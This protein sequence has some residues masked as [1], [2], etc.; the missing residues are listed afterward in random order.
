MMLVRNG[1]QKVSGAARRG[2]MVFI[3]SLSGASG[4]R[5][6]DTPCPIVRPLRR[7]NAPTLYISLTIRDEADIGQ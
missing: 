2:T 5:E 4:L 6:R 1:T 3:C 7:P